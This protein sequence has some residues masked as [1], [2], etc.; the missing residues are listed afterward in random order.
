MS[1]RHLILTIVKTSCVNNTVKPSPT[2]SIPRTT[3]Q[4]MGQILHLTTL[5][6][7]TQAQSMRNTRYKTR[8]YPSSS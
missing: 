3:Q 8:A 7:F 6:K 2:C 4:E 5:T 1:Y